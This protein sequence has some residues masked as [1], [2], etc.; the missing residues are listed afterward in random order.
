MYKS[1]LV[2]PTHASLTRGFEI[3]LNAKWVCTL[4]QM[5]HWHSLAQDPALWMQLSDEVCKVLFHSLMFWSHIACAQKRA[6]FGH[7]G[8][9]SKSKSR[10]VTGVINLAE[11]P[12][13]GITDWKREGGQACT[14]WA[15]WQ[16]IAV[17]NF[18]L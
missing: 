18:A 16:N 3:R 6:A 4:L 8:A 5:G 15:N 10:T 12:L 7:A 14:R 2:S 17:R 1:V 13:G 9:K 11:A